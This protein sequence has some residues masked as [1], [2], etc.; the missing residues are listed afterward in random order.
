MKKYICTI[1]EGNLKEID[2][3]KG[4]CEFCGTEIIYTNIDIDVAIESPKNNQI[5]VNRGSTYTNLSG[6][7]F[8]NINT[9][10]KRLQDLEFALSIEPNNQKL[11]KDLENIQRK[12][13]HETLSLTSN[14]TSNV[15]QLENR[16]RVLEQ[17]IESLVRQTKKN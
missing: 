4:I 8:I 11:I 3:T 15:A 6:R 10:S 7:E 16:I 2:A 13:L 12:A 5:F 9:T 14:M 1:C 17:T